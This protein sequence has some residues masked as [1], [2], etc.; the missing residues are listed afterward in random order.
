VRQQYGFLNRE[1][2]AAGLQFWNNIDQCGSDLNCI[3]VH[4]NTSAAFFVSIEFQQTGYRFIE[5]T[6]LPTGTYRMRRPITRQQ[7]LP[8][9]RQISNGVIVNQDGWQDVLETNKNYFA[10][11]VTRSDF[12]I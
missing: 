2:D 1:P 4:I 6:K 9:T 10:E 8:D 5:L 12:V 11:F 7:F 3:A